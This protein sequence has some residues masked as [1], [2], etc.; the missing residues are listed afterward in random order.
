MDFLMQD[1]SQTP[2]WLW[3]LALVPA[4]LL[5]VSR[6]RENARVD[7]DKRKML[8]LRASIARDMADIYGNKRG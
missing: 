8:E 3:L 6:S 7:E 5:W 1:A 2:I 4:L